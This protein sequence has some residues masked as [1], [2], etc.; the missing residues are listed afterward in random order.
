[1]RLLIEIK[2][3]LAL[4]LGV[5]LALSLATP[6]RATVTTG[7]V[8]DV[9]EGYSIV[10]GSPNP[11]LGVALWWS[12]AGFDDGWL[13]VDGGHENAFATGVT[14]ITQI[15]DASIFD[16]TL[17]AVIGPLCDADCD[18]DGVGDFIVVRGAEGQANEGFY[19]VLRI[20]DVHDVDIHLPYAE[21]DGT[22]WFQTDR[23]GDFSDAVVP[24]PG[25]ALLVL[26]GVA[27]LLRYRSA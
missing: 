14:D 10:I 8:V 19:G 5:L 26:A 22:W 20:D 17:D 4:Q 3:S 27:A 12:I 21:L 2:A 16:F 23:T 9:P 18:P 25:T 7:R 13:Y 1:M 11:P 6:G 24:E 15:S